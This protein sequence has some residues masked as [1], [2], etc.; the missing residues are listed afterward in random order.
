MSEIQ[1]L[2]EDSN[3]ATVFSFF[4]TSTGVNTI[5]AKLPQFL[6]NKWVDRATRYKNSSSVTLFTFHKVH[7]PDQWD[8]INIG[9]PLFHV[10]SHTGHWRTETGTKTKTMFRNNG[11]NR[12]KTG[13]DVWIQI[14]SLV[15]YTP[16]V[17]HSCVTKL[18]RIFVKKFSDEKKGLRVCFR[19]CSLEE[20][21]L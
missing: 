1:C 18:Q 19:C 11:E 8:G 10:W 4:D 6:Q 21:W 5:I 9:R 15:P 17:V 12:C 14:E 7:R 13:Q 3:Y 20:D 16:Q 2:R